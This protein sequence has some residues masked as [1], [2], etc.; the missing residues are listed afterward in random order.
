RMEKFET[1]GAALKASWAKFK[2]VKQMREGIARFTFRKKDGSERAALGTLREGNF[3]YQYKGG[4][5]TAKANIVKYFDIERN[6]FRSFR[7]E[8]LIAA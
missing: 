5:G 6:A 8:N 2:L 3:S 4:K 7:L 1:F